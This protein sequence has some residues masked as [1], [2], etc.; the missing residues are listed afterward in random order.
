MW[1]MLA[2]AVRAPLAAPAPVAPGG[3]Q[4]RAEAQLEHG[5]ALF[6]QGRYAEAEG[7]ARESLATIEAVESEGA[8][9]QISASADLLRSGLEE[10]A[11]SYGFRLRQTGPARMPLVLVDD[12]PNWEKTNALCS[13][14]VK[15]GVYLH[16]WHNMFLCAAH[17]E[18]DIEQALARTDD[19][20]AAVAK[21]FGG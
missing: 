19:A 17:T 14:A 7:P 5:Y 21:A 13:E 1:W 11:A 20:F 4:G 9:E 2:L 8:I 12:D 18:S 3:E 6:E 15:R 16:P 10:Q